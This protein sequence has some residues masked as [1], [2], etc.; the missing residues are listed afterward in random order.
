MKNSHQLSPSIPP[1]LKKIMLYDHSEVDNFDPYS[2]HKL[3]YCDRI[4][5]VINLIE[6]NFPNP[7]NIQIGEFGC[8]QGNMSLLLAERG[9]T[10]TA[11]DQDAAFLEYSQLKYERG[12]IQWIKANFSDENIPMQALDVA[13]LGEIIEH[14]AYPEKVVENISRYVK[15]GGICI[16]TTPNGSRIKA[17]LPTF[18]QVLKNH[19]RDALAQRQFGP[20][21][22]DHLFLFTLKEAINIIPKQ[23]KKLAQG[24]LGGT[25]LINALTL[26]P[27]RYLDHKTVRK[28]IRF[29]SALPII[30]RFTFNNFYLV[31]KK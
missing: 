11:V 30:N 27:L 4:Q 31:F 21:G 13:I 19:S 22:S 10:V 2:I 29:L 1:H 24:Y 9:Y 25:P 26:R 5:T 28:F 16:I 15:P 7:T 23:S 3:N 17:Q 12:T 18:K 20:D 8:A 14:C 6:K